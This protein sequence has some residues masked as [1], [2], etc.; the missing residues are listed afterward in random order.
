M[1]WKAIYN[2]NIK[3]LKL[4]Q[5]EVTSMFFRLGMLNVRR[6]LTRSILVILTLALAAI[7]LTYSLAMQ[8]IPPLRVAPFL[9]RLTGGQILVIP[10]RWAGQHTS[11]VTGAHQFRSAHLLPSGMSWLE[12]FYPELYKQGFWLPSGETP[13]EFIAPEVIE[14]LADFPGVD[15]IVATPM[16]SAVIHSNGNQGIID[17]PIRLAPLTENIVKL[18]ADRQR[19]DQFAL[20]AKGLFFNSSAR[21]LKDKPT[22]E[23]PGQPIDIWLPQLDADKKL[24]FGNAKLSTL[25]FAAYLDVPTRE[26]YW[27]DPLGGLQSEVGLFTGDIVWVGQESWQELIAQVGGTTSLPIGN[28]V[29]RTDLQVVDKTIASLSEAFPQL[30]FINLSQVENR[31][32][33]TGAMEL[34]RRAPRGLVSR[35]EQPGLVMPAS[36]N[37]IFSYL[38]VLIAAILLGGHMLTG[39]AARNQEIGTLRALGA[40][41]RDILTLGISETIALTIIGVTIGFFPLRVLGFIMQLRGGQPLLLVI[42]GTL[43]EYGQILGLALIASLSFAIFPVWRLSSVAPME[44]LRNE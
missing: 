7:S 22:Y 21:I 25:P 18:T 15:A 40:R 3:R 16:L 36:F 33:Q 30:T 10:L 37:R 14:S 39:V 20:Q 44:V 34:F 35:V 6:Q 31:L 24:D 19:P 38:L 4:V 13:S 2:G 27:P 26:V 1:V 8:E 42:L 28:L 41:R 9:G 43:L 5:P 12:W 29:L 23:Q 11:D 32:F 17:Y